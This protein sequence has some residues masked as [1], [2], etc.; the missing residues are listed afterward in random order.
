M[1]YSSFFV[2]HAYDLWKEKKSETFLAA[3]FSDEI[4]DIFD[5]VSRIVTTWDHLL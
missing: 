1:K 4:E 5:I 2:A 3:R